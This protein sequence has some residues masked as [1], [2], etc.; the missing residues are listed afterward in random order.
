M[1]E[2]TETFSLPQPALDG[3]RG[4][5]LRR[6][7]SPDEMPREKLVRRGR[8]ALT[9]EELIAIFLRTGLPGCHVLEL[10]RQIK[11]RA[12]S[13]TALGKLEASEIM[14]LVKGIGP[15]KATALAAVFELG[16]RA[17]QEA[18]EMKRIEK[19]EDVY[20]LMADD[21]RYEVQEHFCVL[22]LNARNEVIHNSHIAVGTLSRVVLHPRDVFRDPIR[23]GAMRI[24]LAHNHPSGNPE[25]S[26]QDVEL[27]ERLVQAG[28]TLLIPVADHVIIGIRSS[29]GDRKPYYSFRE[30]GKIS[31][32]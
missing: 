28:Q 12:G 30:E 23:H 14:E 18:P 22:S 19:P 5:P 4:E 24:I 32:P 2:A 31:A 6:A 20:N 1:S 9:D 16:K 13:L 7:V 26:S 27:T 21:L 3:G 11:R 10:A 29:H 17:V 15:A 8:K 25:P